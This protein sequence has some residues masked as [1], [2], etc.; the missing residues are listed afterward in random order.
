MKLAAAY[1]ATQGQCK[2]AWDKEHPQTAPLHSHCIVTN[3]KHVRVYGSSTPTSQHTCRR[4]AAKAGLNDSRLKH[5]SLKTGRRAA[6]VW[7][8]VGGRRGSAAESMVAV[9]LFSNQTQPQTFIRVGR[10]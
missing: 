5:S 2:V 7:S 1:C 10:G 3:P 9:A 4:H 8:Q 6:S